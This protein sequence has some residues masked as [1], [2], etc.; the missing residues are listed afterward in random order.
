M[1]RLVPFFVVAT[2]PTPRLSLARKTNFATI[3]PHSPQTQRF[4]LLSL[5]VSFWLEYY[6]ISDWNACLTTALRLEAPRLLAHASW[7]APLLHQHLTSASYG[8][9]DTFCVHSWKDLRK[10]CFCLGPGVS[11]PLP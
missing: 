8:L 2:P 7:S 3:L 9:L 11:D 1:M 5:I 4:H 10:A 6:R